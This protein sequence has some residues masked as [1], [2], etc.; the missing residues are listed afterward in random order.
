MKQIGTDRT[1]ASRLGTMVDASLEQKRV[2]L[3]SADP[4]L[5]VAFRDVVRTI[6]LALEMDDRGKLNHGVRVAVLA[7][8]IGDALGMADAANLYYA[9]LLHDLGAMG[10]AN[11]VLHD[12]MDGVFGLDVHQHGDRG[13][14][15]VRP[16][17]ALRPFEDVIRD[18]HE[19]VDGKG[20]PSQKR[21]PEI[22]LGASVVRVADQIEMALRVA[23]P[24]QRLER[25]QRTLARE[26]D[27]G[28][29]ERVADAASDLFASEASLIELLCDYEA[30]EDALVTFC[31]APFGIP[32]LSR[33]EM[34]SQLL[35]VLARVVDAKHSY[36]MGHS[37]RVAYYGYRIAHAFSG[38]L[39]V[40]DAAWAGLLHDV[41]KV[42][43][44]RRLLD[45]PGG[46]APDELDI[47]RQHAAD[48]HRIISTIADLSHL[49]LPAASHHERYDGRGYP[50]GL[51]GDEIPLIG[52]ILAYADVY[53]AL[54]TARSYR[55]AIPHTQAL[56]VVRT[57]VGSHLDPR[58]GRVAFDILDRW[59]AADPAQEEDVSFSSFFMS[60]E[61]DL[62]GAFV[63]GATADASTRA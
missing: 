36:T 32:S 20:F 31:P 59:G 57:M 58:I 37:A 38:E 35:W 62:E 15:I 12:V 45:K 40:W 16:L 27:G 5:L 46:L 4:E 30:L 6:S 29:P 51:A 3:G 39:N 22:P 13:A 61:V 53:D 19:R 8:R 11:Q 14:L 48:S 63:P 28:V 56:S 43:V 9:G 33:I 26:R 60:D 24:A 47:V 49:A 44:P 52:R 50:R 54:T 34:L 18:H 23:S 17:A 10:V 2:R 41:G 1:P 21:G 42:G 7:Y 25:V 55:G